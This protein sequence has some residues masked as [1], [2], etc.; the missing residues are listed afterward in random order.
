MCSSL[1][2]TAA[3][4][5]YITM[6]PTSKAILILP[7]SNSLQRRTI[8]ALLPSQIPTDVC[9]QEHWWHNTSH[10]LQIYSIS[11]MHSIMTQLEQFK[12]NCLCIP[13]SVYVFGAFSESPV[14]WYGSYLKSKLVVRGLRRTTVYRR[15]QDVRNKGCIWLT[16]GFANCVCDISWK[17]I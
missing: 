17:M 14:V 8:D 9:Y 3:T 11:S 1:I 10:Q 2:L 4:V 13:L 5:E 7:N 12:T 6:H 15:R 16:F